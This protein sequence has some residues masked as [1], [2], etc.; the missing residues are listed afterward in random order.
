[1]A[2]NR[3]YAREYLKDPSI[4]R[5]YLKYLKNPKVKNHNENA[6]VVKELQLILKELKQYSLDELKELRQRA[7]DEQFM[8]SEDQDIYGYLD[9]LNFACKKES[10]V[11]FLNLRNKRKKEAETESELKECRRIEANKQKK[12]LNYQSQE[13]NA[14][15]APT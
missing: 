1:M 6:K 2:R 15:S 5:D 11:R 10:W 9:D 3:D 7:L 13:A 14:Y 8:S 4:M 12:K